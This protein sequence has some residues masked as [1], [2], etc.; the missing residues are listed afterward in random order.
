MPVA[1][2]ILLGLLVLG[3]AGCSVGPTVACSNRAGYNAAVQRSSNEQLLLNM[4]RLKY[5]E[6]MLFLQVG[7]IASHFN[8][9]AGA[10][11]SASFPDASPD[12]YGAGASASYSEQPTLTYTPLEGEQFASR[13]LTE[14]DMGTFALLVRGGWNIE[15][16]MRIMVER[17]GPLRNYPSASAAGGPKT[18]YERFIEVAHAWRALQREGRLSFLRVSGEPVTVAEDI[19]AGGLGLSDYLS[20]DQAGY[21]LRPV[22]DGY[23]LTRSGPPTLVVEA[24]YAD[25]A[26]A[27][28]TAELL[29]VQP[30]RRR[31]NG[32][33]VDRVRLVPSHAF[34]VADAAPDEVPVQLRSYSDLLYYVAQ[35]I[36]VPEAHR[37]EGRIKVYT[38]LEGN[39][40]NRR[41][42]TS[43]LLDVR[44]S[45]SRPADAFVAVRY[46]GRWFYIADTD[47]GSKDAFA[48][49]SIVFALQSKESRAMPVLTLPVS[50]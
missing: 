31:V 8:Y 37:R 19:P 25:A 20:V 42:F 29:G 32:R 43:D 15:D 13:I 45:E 33:V 39:P 44:C 27:D 34:S 14:T 7:S 40:V 26:A 16:V 41:R 47:T 49:L 38:D 17:V 24:E 1:G 22:E 36:E 35:G 21:A 3:A 30:Q 46:R 9:S 5:R 10:S 11:A 4:V 18:S 23:E 48:L 6:P 50:G 12:T 2:T 28:R